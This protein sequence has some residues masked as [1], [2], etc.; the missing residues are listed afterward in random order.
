MVEVPTGIGEGS[1]LGPLVFLVAILETSEVM[2]R[3]R[4]T[5]KRRHNQQLEVMEMKRRLQDLWHEYQ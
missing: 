4:K 1:V 5:V 2:V 3:V